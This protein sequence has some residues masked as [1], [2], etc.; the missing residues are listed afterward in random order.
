MKTNKKYYAVKSGRIP[1]V[2]ETWSEC[3]E[4]VKGY[5]GAVYKS[6]KSKT[7]AENFIKDD[8]EKYTTDIKIDTSADSENKESEILSKI[9]DDEM[10]AYVDGS[11]NSKDRVFGYGVVMFTASGKVEHSG[12]STCEDCVDFRNVAGEVYGAVYAIK[13]AI[14]LKIKVLYLH[15]DYTG[16]K[17]WAKGEWK[18]NNVLTKRYH[19][20]YNSIKDILKVQF[21]KVEAHTGDTFNEEADK[22]AKQACGIS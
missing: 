8:V 14:H 7:D 4:Q 6:F 11:F 19:D 9:K 5:S 20:Y 22:L 10:V 16:I 17:H 12:C 21:V 18:R 3:E 2:Y 13:K 15:Y 1:G